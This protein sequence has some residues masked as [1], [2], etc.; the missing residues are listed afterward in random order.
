MNISN[1]KPVVTCFLPLYRR[2]VCTATSVRSTHCRFPRE[3]RPYQLMRLLSTVR[4]PRLTSPLNLVR[5]SNQKRSHFKDITCLYCIGCL[6]VTISLA[7]I[8]INTQLSLWILFLYI[9]LQW[10]WCCVSLV[11]FV[12]SCYSYF[13]W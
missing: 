12:I 4:R 6:W 9:G 11:L 8:R 1:G 10:S 2:R 5:T 7:Y 3:S 13:L